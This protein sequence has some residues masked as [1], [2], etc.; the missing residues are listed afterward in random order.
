MNDDNKLLLIIS[1][2]IVLIAG[3]LVVKL[4]PN[5]AA[6]YSVNSFYVPSDRI[7]EG[8]FDGE[9]RYGIKNCPGID[10]TKPQGTVQSVNVYG[11]QI[12]CLPFTTE[13]SANSVYAGLQTGTISLSTSDSI[14]ATTFCQQL[15]AKEVEG[16]YEIV[17]PFNFQWLVS[18][19]TDRDKDI[20]IRSR[21]GKYRMTVSGIVNWYC[22]GVPVSAESDEVIGWG[23]HKNQ[24]ITRIGQG[25][26]ISTGFA[27][28][29]IA[30]G[31]E[32]TTIA[33]DKME[34]SEDGMS[35]W[36][37]ISLYDLVKVT[38]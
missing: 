29:L 14:T 21:D 5:P 8:E 3:I 37:S 24:H 27:G 18:N 19:I 20:V 33:F 6:V 26:D 34:Y 4:W 31:D 15:E 7:V 11:A 22:A 35:G 10:N 9:S 28:Q 23:N 13:S 30:Y 36:T 2:I 1:F 32:S 25:T 17:A 16:Y 12:S 38:E